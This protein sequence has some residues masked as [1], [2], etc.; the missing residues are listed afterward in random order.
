V[1]KR[2]LA[3]EPGDAL[4]PYRVDV[5]IG[6][7]G[8][9]GTVV[10]ATHS[11]D[12]ATVAIKVFATPDV[13][14]LQ[15]V[16]REARASSA[17]DHPN[18]VRVLDLSGIAHAP[19]FLVMEHLSGG[20]LADW[21]AASGPL[22]LQDVVR[23]AGELG[24]AL[25]ALHRAGF[26]HRDIKPSN[27][28]LRDD[29]SAVLTDLGLV[30]GDALS[31]V[32]APGSV[33]GTIDYLAPEVVRGGHASP[34]S[35]IYA[36]GCVFYESLAGRPPF[37]DRPALDVARA[38]IEDNPAGLVTLR[39]DVSP[40]FADMLALALAKQPSERPPTATAYARLLRMAQLD[41]TAGTG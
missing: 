38:H 19:P 31:A 10:R 18:I 4:G 22:E 39:S 13:E 29:R 26:V 11:V 30:G 32:T 27:I 37:S 15:R 8:S 33:L 21:L 6:R 3:I 2:G 36:L 20:S 17:L 9:T 41:P 28:L 25:D 34:A 40:A 23:L 16:F 12:G 24:D 1:T 7:G 5:V 14:V 35:D